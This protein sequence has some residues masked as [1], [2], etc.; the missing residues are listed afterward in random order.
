MVRVPEGEGEREREGER[1]SGRGMRE[2][3]EKVRDVPTDGQA[4]REKGRD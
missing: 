3:R 2:R 1:G 4:D